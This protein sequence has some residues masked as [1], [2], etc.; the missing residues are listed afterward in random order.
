[1]Q[2]GQREAEL[3]LE[4]RVLLGLLRGDE[5]G[6]EG[7]DG[8]RLHGHEDA[9]E[10]ELCDQQLIRRVDLAGCAALELHHA[11]RVQVAQPAQHCGAAV[12][13]LA[14]AR[15]LAVQHLGAQLLRRAFQLRLLLQQRRAATTG[16]IPAAVAL[17]LCA[18]CKQ[19]V[20]Q[21]PRLQ[22]RNLLHGGHELRVPDLHVL[23]R[24]QPRQARGEA[25][26]QLCERQTHGGARVGGA[27]ILGQLD[28]EGGD[29]GEAVQQHG[30]HV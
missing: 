6:A 3:R 20:L 13:L 29:A 5:A 2:R 19:R 10:H 9:L 4:G 23:N 26:A 25:G 27:Q 17:R 14:E 16:G 22:R 12:E 7:G 21:E 8:G 30:H 28:H 11:C 24:V 18:G 1:M 15:N